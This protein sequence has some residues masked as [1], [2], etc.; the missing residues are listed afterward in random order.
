MLRNISCLLA[1]ALACSFCSSVAGE[2]TGDYA[3]LRREAVKRLERLKTLTANAKESGIDTARER[4]TIVT[5]EQFL[6]FAD[7]DIEHTDELIEECKAYYLIGD[8]AEPYSKE[9]PYREV[10]EV[11]MIVDGAI[12]ELRDVMQRPSSRRPVPDVDHAKL[13]LRD[14][15]LHFE[16][17][18]TFPSS[19]SWMPRE[20][21]LLDAFGNIGS[22]VIAP[23]FKATR[24]GQA[25]VAT[26]SGAADETMGRVFFT[27]GKLPTWAREA[28]ENI[29][30]AKRCFT[31]Y[32]I[33]HPGA[34]EF[35]EALMQDT[36]P[37]V[38]GKNVSR[39]GY[40]L[41]NEPHWFSAT[42][43]WDTGPVSE[44]TV[45]KFRTWLAEKHGTVAELNQ[46]WKTDFASFADV[47]IEIP[48]DQE[49]RGK[50]IWYDWCR[51]NMDRVSEYFAFLKS[52][53]RKHDPDAKV[54]IK[55]LPDHLTNPSRSHGMDME[56]LVRLQD[57]VGCDVKITNASM[58][59]EDA[60]WPKR[61]A[62]NWHEIAISYDFFRSV[63]PDKMIFDSEFHGLSTVHWRDPDL[64]PEYV[65]CIYWLAHLHGLGINTTWY[66]GREPDGSMLDRDSKSF[67]ASNLTQPRVMDAFGRTMKELNA[68][69]PEVVALSTQPKH[70]R[71]FY[72]E[73]EA[74]NNPRYM[75]KISDVY[76][77]LYHEGFPLGFATGRMLSEASDDA[78]L[79]QSVLVVA[80]AQHLTAAEL[81]ALRHYLSQGG[82]MVI[83]KSD[84]Y[85]RPHA[86]TLAAISERLMRGLDEGSSSIVSVVTGHLKAKGLL[87]P[88]ALKESNA[89]GEPGCVWRTCPYEDGHLLLVLNL[90][91]STAR[92]ALAEPSS[93]CRDL[94]TR[95]L[96]PSTF[97]LAPFG[98]ELLHVKQRD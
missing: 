83:T 65:R 15:Y 26:E 68:F 2:E 75:H 23:A 40:L 91:K 27:H 43:E 57:I 84:E 76:E 69:A 25:K 74:I 94:L 39:G 38:A 3:S 21:E 36:V 30:F 24:D 31:D 88:V 58:A 64:S 51:F 61:Y 13:E 56:M 72:S 85:G 14:G 17:R 6:K 90:G 80:G 47:T 77:E 89:V 87:S 42:D 22:A 46:L 12:A 93:S 67:F 41:A 63:G 8:R 98:V 59:K 97:E 95:A 29:E 96:H 86:T 81:D 50:P 4:V 1:V 28:Y 48:I 70:V 73:T 16:G 5:A 78:S 71:L 11:R 52:E 92:L 37:Q 10:R 44:F 45:D 20:P 49:L 62:V 19:I 18:P 7:W 79:E 82:A 60:A 34:R 9:L 55:I 54:H 32:D 35:W 33:D 66:W 53:V